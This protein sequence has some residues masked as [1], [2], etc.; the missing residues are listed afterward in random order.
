M[1][2]SIAKT[3][4]C[5]GFFLEGD[6]SRYFF[7]AAFPLAGF[8]G[9]FDVAFFTGLPLPFAAPLPAARAAARPAMRPNT[10]PD[11]RPVPSG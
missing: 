2:R 11:M 9:F 5:P 4:A 1:G 10:A 6:K 8:A 7:F 3:G